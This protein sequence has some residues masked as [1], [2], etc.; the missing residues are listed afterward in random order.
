MHI[1]SH[2]E[3]VF[4]ACEDCDLPPGECP[5]VGG[6]H[7]LCYACGELAHDC[8]DCSTARRCTC[9]VPVAVEGDE[10]VEIPAETN[11]QLVWGVR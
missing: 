3:A 2:N 8:D 9:P 7:V 6:V 10:T 4:R 5:A 1:N 11:A